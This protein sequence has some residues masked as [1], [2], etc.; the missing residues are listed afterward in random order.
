MVLPASADQPFL[1]FISKYFD[2]N[3]NT[4]QEIFHNSVMARI[5]SCD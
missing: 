3:E 1:F 4:P 5:K 2:I